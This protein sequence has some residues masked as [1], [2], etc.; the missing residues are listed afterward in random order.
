MRT[1]TWRPS[2]IVDTLIGSLVARRETV[3]HGQR[4][5][6]WLDCGSHLAST[7]SEAVIVL[8]MFEVESRHISPDGARR[9]LHGH[10]SRSEELFIIK[11]RVSR[12]EFLGDFSSIREKPGSHRSCVYFPDRIL[13]HP[14]FHELVVLVGLLVVPPENGLHPL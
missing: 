14:V 12:T 8:E 1:I 3:H 11:D 2:S 4:I 7:A 9:R 10:H 13:V 6:I 5:K